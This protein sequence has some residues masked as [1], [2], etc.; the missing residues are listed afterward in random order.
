MVDKINKEENPEAIIEWGRKW[1]PLFG[2]S[3][4][5]I[6]FAIGWYQGNRVGRMPNHAQQNYQL[7]L[8]ALLYG[9]ALCGM[10]A[11]VITKTTMWMMNVKNVT[12]QVILD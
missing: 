3:A 9:T 11:I 6:G 5:P 12:I 7:A 2:I 1:I 4:L 10:S 8:K